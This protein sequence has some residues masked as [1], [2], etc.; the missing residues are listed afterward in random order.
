MDEKTENFIKKSKLKH[1]NK[2]DYS[3]SIFISAKNKI[4]IICFIHGKFYQL[5]SNHYK[6]EGCPYC[7]EN[8]KMIISL[9][10]E[11]IKSIFDYDTSLVNLINMK[12]KV[13]LICRIHGEFE[14]RPDHLLNGFGCIICSENKKNIEKKDK[15]IK[16]SIQV[17]NN[18]YDYSLVEYKN[19]SIKVKIIC[20]E[21]G[22][23]L[24]EPLHHQR[25]SGCPVCQESKG[26]K[27]IAEFLL[28]YKIEFERQK[29]FKNCKNKKQLFFD[30]Y[31][32]LYN[33]CI[34][35]DGKQHFSSVENW[36]GEKGLIIIK[37]RDKIKNKYCKDNNIR[38]YRIKYTDD[39]IE[40]LKEITFLL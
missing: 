12:T 22:I 2:Y 14:Q 21:H 1:G 6:G 28:N 30:F 18:K 35:Y 20:P 29:K 36:G 32:P 8:K 7:S 34:E 13:K 15:F 27:K 23:F 17:H 39:I 26:E 38:L 3:Q 25:G 4:K 11:K 40:K 19:N 24:Q 9:F 33:I 37:E 5:S 31:L 16:L 10:I